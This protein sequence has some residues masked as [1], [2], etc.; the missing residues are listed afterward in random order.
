MLVRIMRMDKMSVKEHL[1]K[2][3]DRKVRFWK[4]TFNSNPKAPYIPEIDKIIH[5]QKKPLMMKGMHNGFPLCI[6]ERQQ[7]F[8]FFG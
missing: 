4:E 2:C 7:L 1:E 5:L 6:R 8:E 3:F